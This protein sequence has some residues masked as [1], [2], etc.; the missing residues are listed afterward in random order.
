MQPL[1]LV[2]ISLGTHG[3]GGVP[4][5]L[6]STTGDGSYPNLYTAAHRR[7]IA[8][9]LKHPN[10]PGARRHLVGR[11]GYEPIS[12]SGNHGGS[13]QR[14]SVSVLVS[15]NR[16]SVRSH[17]DPQPY[18]ELPVGCLRTGRTSH[19]PL[20]SSSFMVWPHLGGGIGEA[21]RLL[22]RRCRNSGSRIDPC[23]APDGDM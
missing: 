22:I 2:V 3:C 11:L 21:R 15:F 1:H 18:W 9:G 13:N 14:A 16:P 6:F 8:V 19:Q 5:Y 12:P 23:Q 7:R 10:L 20:E 17:I 4:K